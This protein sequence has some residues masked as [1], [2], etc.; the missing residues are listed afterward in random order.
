VAFSFAVNS[1]LAIYHGQTYEIRDIL[2]ICSFLITTFPEQ[3]QNACAMGRDESDSLIIFSDYSQLTS[4][5]VALTI[6]VYV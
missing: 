5:F 1:T 3:V 6:A 4:V 2:S